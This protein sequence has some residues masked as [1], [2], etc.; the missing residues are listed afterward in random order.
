LRITAFN[1][2][3]RGERGNTHI[4]VSEFLEG[5]ETAGAEVDNILLADRHRPVHRGC[6]SHV[7]RSPWEDVALGRPA[8]ERT[9]VQE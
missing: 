7:G 5:A 4:M 6:Q 1:G 3:P 2:S 9:C 8:G